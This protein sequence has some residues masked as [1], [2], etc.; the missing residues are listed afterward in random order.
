MVPRSVGVGSQDLRDPDVE[1]LGRHDRGI[2][3]RSSG[4]DKG[5]NREL[6]DVEGVSLREV[7]RMDCR[8]R[9]EADE[10]AREAISILYMSYERTGLSAHHGDMPFL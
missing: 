1:R 9:R 4:T 8:A 7:K 6:H 5:H 3:K 2:G 10:V